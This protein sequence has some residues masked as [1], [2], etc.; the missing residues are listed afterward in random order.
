MTWTQWRSAGMG[1]TPGEDAYS[2]PFLARLLHSLPHLNV[3]F[4]QVNNSFDPQSPVYLEVSQTTCDTI[5]NTPFFCLNWTKNW[6]KK[7]LL[8]HRLW[9]N[10]VK[11]GICQK[12]SSKTNYFRLLKLVKCQAS[13]QIWS[14]ILLLALKI[15]KKC[16]LH[17]YSFIMFNK[18]DSFW[19][20][21]FLK[22]RL[23]DLKISK[24]SPPT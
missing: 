17:I 23:R 14:K 22:Y 16:H 3:T 11:K 24:I 10:T 2:I 13:S 12:R 15:R 21:K 4:H 6:H 18:K 20:T 1:V 19:L 8:Q 7:A 9:V 5:G